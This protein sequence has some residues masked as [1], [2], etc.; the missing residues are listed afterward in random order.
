MR[1]PRALCLIREAPIYRRQAFISG[2]RAAGYMVDGD[3]QNPEPDDVLVIWNR[4]GYGDDRARQFERAK[5]RVVVV[6]NGYMGK[7]W[8]GDR[9]FA[10]ALGQHNGAGSWT[11]GDAARWD[12]LGIEPEPWRTGGKDRIILAQRGIGSSGMRSPPGWA[13]GVLRK[14]GGRIRIHPG[15][16]PPTVS[17][18][19]D[20]R[21]AASVITWGSSAALRAILMGLPVWYEFPKWIGALAARP[22]SE[23]FGPG[24][25]LAPV[26]RSDADR[27]EMLRRMIWAMWR[28]SE[29]ENGTAFRT[30]LSNA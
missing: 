22:L 10:M 11:V 14:Y 16:E 15:N 12:A 26:K 18:E 23:F 17:L 7:S 3:F 24:R 4:Y 29:V 2:L 28:V 9:W 27:L 1:R 19:D 30:L 13:E 20:L 6:E 5:A 21:E 25:T 8:L